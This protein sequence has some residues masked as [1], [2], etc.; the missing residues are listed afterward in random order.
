[1]L[2]IESSR[3]CVAAVFMLCVD[4]TEV[5]ALALGSGVGVTAGG[6]RAGN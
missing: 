4:A 5:V 3:W 6:I 2:L 1:M